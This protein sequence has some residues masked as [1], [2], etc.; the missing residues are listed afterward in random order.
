MNFKE[1]LALST[2][3]LFAGLGAFLVE[4]LNGG[5]FCGKDIKPLV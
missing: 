2:V 4:I 5:T 3:L 1:G